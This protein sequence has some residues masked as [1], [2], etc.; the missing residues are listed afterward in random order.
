MSLIFL[1][2]SL[3]FLLYTSDT[4]RV[5][6]MSSEHTYKEYAVRTMTGFLSSFQETFYSPTYKKAYKLDIQDAMLTWAQNYTYEFHLFNN[7]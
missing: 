6:V 4:Y 1:R 5:D 2:C 3:S 7:Q